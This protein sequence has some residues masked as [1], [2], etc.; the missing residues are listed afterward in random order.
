MVASTAA[1]RKL[2]AVIWSMLTHRR[3]FRDEDPGL[4][5]RKRLNLQA[6]PEPGCSGS[7]SPEN[8]GTRAQV[9]GR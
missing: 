4:S 8:Q 5:A 2:L 9:S 1:A 7:G 3:P 6:W